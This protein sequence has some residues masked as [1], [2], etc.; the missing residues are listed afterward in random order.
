MVYRIGHFYTVKL[1]KFSLYAVFVQIENYSGFNLTL[2]YDDVVCG[3]NKERG[4]KVMDELSLV[5]GSKCC[6]PPVLPAVLG[7]APQHG[8][9]A[10]PQHRRPGIPHLRQPLLA[11]LPPRLQDSRLQF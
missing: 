10:L 5:Y 11:T 8:A 3:Y 1:D 6:T 4:D 7:G 2:P 9:A